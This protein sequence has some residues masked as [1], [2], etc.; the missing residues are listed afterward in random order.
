MSKPKR[1]RRAKST[2]ARD[3]GPRPDAIRSGRI[4]A[5][6]Q[7]AFR[8]AERDVFDRLEVSDELK[9]IG[10]EFAALYRAG[11]QLGDAR[12]ADLEVGVRGTG[13]MSD[14]QAAAHARLR[15]ILREVPVEH[16]GDAI[17]LAEDQAVPA[18]RAE[19]ALEAVALA[20]V[21]LARRRRHDRER[22]VA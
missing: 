19:R 21:V 20:L 12:A 22:G 13:E 2:A 10:R 16:R 4:M 6:D 11:R 5:L 15:A 1:R 14:A 8:L 18:G 9:I 7:R 17:R 3:A